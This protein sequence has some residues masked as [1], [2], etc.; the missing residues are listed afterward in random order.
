M[1][2]TSSEKI[3]FLPKFHCYKNQPMGLSRIDVGEKILLLVASTLG[4]NSCEE[5]AASVNIA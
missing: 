1:L 5:I 4:E 3:I 2:F